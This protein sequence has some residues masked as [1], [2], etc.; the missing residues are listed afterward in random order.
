VRGPHDTSKGRHR[1][2]SEELASAKARWRKQLD[3]IEAARKA[4]TAQQGDSAEGELPETYG[5]WRPPADMLAQLS[6]LSCLDM[7]PDH[8]RGRLALEIHYIGDPSVGTI[9]ESVDVVEDTMNAPEL[10]EC[11]SESMYMLEMDPPTEPVRGVHKLAYNAGDGDEIDQLLGLLK[12]YVKE[13]P[14]LGEEYPAIGRVLE[15]PDDAGM[16]EWMTPEFMKTMA[17]HPE[18]N[19]ELNAYFTEKLGKREVPEDEPPPQ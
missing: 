10:R 14:E 7:L 17:E 9:V 8:P 6:E 4:S 2:T 3:A 15:L 1:P 13:H 18:L 11:W 19:E 12:Q 5:D 16:S